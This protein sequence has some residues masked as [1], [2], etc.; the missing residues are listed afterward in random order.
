MSPRGR[1]AAVDPQGLHVTPP[2]GAVAAV[3]LEVARVAT[4]PPCR[5]VSAGTK[6]WS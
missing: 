2:R 3:R 5:D 6:W 1:G 4:P